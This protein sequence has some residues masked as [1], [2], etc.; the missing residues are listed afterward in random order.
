MLIRFCGFL[1]YYIK[2]LIVGSF[3]TSVII[4]YAVY[5]YKWLKRYPAY[6]RGLYRLEKSP[7]LNVDEVYKI[8]TDALPGKKM[9]VIAKG[10]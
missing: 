3:F 1:L 9:F 4:S 8:F 2:M 10:I 6:L 5:V 7:V